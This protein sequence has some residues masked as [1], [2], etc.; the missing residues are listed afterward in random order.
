MKQY[1]RISSVL[2][3]AFNAEDGLSLEVSKRLY[4]RLVTR[5]PGFEGFKAELA[6]AFENP[7]TSWKSLLLNDQYEVY[8]AIN[9]M[10]ARDYAFS[11][12]WLPLQDNL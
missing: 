5:S 8:D 6:E 10:E 2:K 3:T 4:E 7:R 11:I 12:L 9:E 1:S